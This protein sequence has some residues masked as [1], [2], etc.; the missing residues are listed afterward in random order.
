[1]ENKELA[2]KIIALVGGKSNISQSWHCITRLRFNLIDDSKVEKNEINELAGVI[3]S[4][5]SGGQYL[6]LI[7]I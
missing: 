3:G 4:Q 6:S 1:M 7:H 2:K 5:F